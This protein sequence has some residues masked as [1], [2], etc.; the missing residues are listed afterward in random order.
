[1]LERA[2]A[3]LELDRPGVVG[4]ARAAT[5]AAANGGYVEQVFVAEGQEVTEG[6]VLAYVDAS[7]YR[8]QLDQAKAQLDQAEVELKRLQALGDL[9]SPAQ[10][11]GAGTQQ[12]VARASLSQAQNRMA[13]A[14]IRAPF[15]GVVATVGVEQGESVAP[16][17]P[18][19]RVVQL[20]PAVVNLSVADRDVVSIEKGMPVKVTAASRSKTFDGT[21]SRV[22]PAADL[23]TRSFPVEVEVPN[24]ERLLLPGMIARVKAERPLFQDAM[25]IPQDWIVTKRD[26]RGVFVVNENTA[27]WRDIELGD[28]L[29]DRVLIKSGLKPGDRVVVTGHRDLVDGDALVVSREGRCCKN[30]RTTFTAQS[31]Q[32]P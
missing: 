14:V 18:V 17:A 24:E 5:L 26:R 2:A 12:K 10:L 22:S 29:H 9:A 23:R 31:A 30:G 7:L 16:G 15:A 25:V 1:G 4:G 19:V 13:R 32:E 6:Q 11:D 20:D 28:V 27:V 3:T 8:A 21:V